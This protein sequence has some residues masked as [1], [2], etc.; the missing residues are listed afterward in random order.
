MQLILIEQARILSRQ[1]GIP[2]SLE[3]TVRSLWF[4][5]L[6]LSQLCNKQD[7]PPGDGEVAGEK[8]KD[9]KAPEADADSDSDDEQDPVDLDVNT[10]SDLDDF[11]TD[12]ESDDSQTNANKI[13]V[14][15]IK[16]DEDIDTDEE[17]RKIDEKIGKRRYTK[18]A[19]E[20][21]ECKKPIYVCIRIESKTNSCLR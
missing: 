12:Y 7:K 1:E 17:M 10:E 21:R 19:L 11:D 9:K 13:P 4:R 5:W 6:E 14:P 8:D 15:N 2:T 3:N 16:E 18:R 20:Q